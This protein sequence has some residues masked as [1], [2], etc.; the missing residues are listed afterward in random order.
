MAADMIELECP[1]CSE[2][3][4]LDIGFAG[5]VCRCSACGT[6]MT[7]PGKGGAQR[8]EALSRPDRPDTPGGGRPEAPG[9]PESPGRAV[10]AQPAEAIA[11]ATHQTFVTSTGRVVTIDA[12][13]HIPTA[14]KRQR[15]A[16]R[17]A[18]VAVFCTLVL[19]VLAACIFALVTL[20]G[21]S[22]E[23]GTNFDDPTHLALKVFTFDPTAN[24]LQIEHPNVLGLPLSKKTAIVY[25]P[26][27]SA[28][29]ARAM[30]VSALAK[31]LNHPNVKLNLAIVGTDAAKPA[32]FGGGAIGLASLSAEKLEEF[33]HALAP[34]ADQLGP[35]ITMA[36]A[37]NPEQLIVITSQRLRAEDMTPVT[38]AVASRP[39]LVIDSVAV[40]TD[41]P[42]LEDL[43]VS[44]NGNYVALS[45]MRMRAWA[46]EAITTEP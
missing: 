15:K 6:L 30:V 4:E 37:S 7:V 35:A 26:F 19:S 5:G 22:P 44:R 18:T 46:E 34:T 10:P 14:A 3:L 2:L 25:D 13:V 9:R 38:D 31:G 42:S 29:D 39:S 28:E 27:D 36:L 11:A 1:S 32:A 33:L 40:N 45:T 12:G 17:I 41:S 8:A 23:P 43:V 16:V 21:K 20:A 24:P